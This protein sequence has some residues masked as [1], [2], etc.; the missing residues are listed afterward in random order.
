MSK[1]KLV[2]CFISICFVFLILPI[3]GTADQIE[4]NLFKTKTKKNNQV[5]Y[6]QAYRYR[7][8]I[9]FGLRLMGGGTYLLQNDINDYIQGIN[10]FLSDIPD[11]EPDL[12]VDPNLTPA[13]TGIDLSGELFINFNPHVGIGF[14]AGYIL[15]E[16]ESSG[17][18]S[19]S[20]RNFEN[21]TVYPKFSAIPL[22]FSL[23]FGGSLGG[24]SRIMLNGGV[25]YYLGTINFDIIEEAG[26]PTASMKST[27]SWSTKSNEIGFHGGINFEFGFSRNFAF[28]IG[29]QGRYVQFTD[30]TGDLEEKLRLSNGFSSSDTKEDQTLWFGNKEMFTTH[31][32]YPWV[33]FSENKPTAPWFSDVRKAEISL[34][35]ITLQGGIKLTF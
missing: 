5:T 35:G 3:N 27:Q 6:Q 11:Y 20:T 9:E 18:L 16:K 12:S 19:D 4:L 8:G 26:D 14:G 30:L 17:G 10:D 22:T 15:V 34:N 23:Y 29:T 28:V 2:E 13:N 33:I 25:G 7:G 32:E 31:K 21:I 1:K 24:L